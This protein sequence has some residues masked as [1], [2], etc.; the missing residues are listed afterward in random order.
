MVTARALAST[1][2]IISI[3]DH[4]LKEDGK[5]LLLKGKEERIQEELQSIDKKLHKCEIIKLDNK[6]EERHILQ[7]TKEKK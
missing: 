5:Y 6:K 3:C 1:K 7:I 4:L 2:K